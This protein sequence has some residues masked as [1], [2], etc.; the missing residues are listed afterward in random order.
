MIEHEPV[1][2]DGV[3]D[4]ILLNY[5]EYILWATSTDRIAGAARHPLRDDR[6]LAE[7][8]GALEKRSAT[9]ICLP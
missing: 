7:F 8:S 6:H 4:L 5:K 1:G 9:T 2:E 3:A